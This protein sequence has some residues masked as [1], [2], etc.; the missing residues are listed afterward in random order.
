MSTNEASDNMTAN[1]VNQMLAKLAIQD[2]VRRASK[3]AESMTDIAVQEA[4][5]SYIGPHTKKPS[6]N[7]PAGF[8]RQGVIEALAE[9]DWMAHGL[10]VIRFCRDLPEVAGVEDVVAELDAKL[11]E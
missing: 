7:T 9:C 5:Y 6:L 4:M 3:F 1:P 8:V 11:D 2:T 10:D